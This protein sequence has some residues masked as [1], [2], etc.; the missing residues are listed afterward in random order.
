MEHTLD[1]TNKGLPAAI[2]D[3]HSP[4]TLCSILSYC[5]LRA[6]WSGAGVWQ[7]LLLL[8]WWLLLACWL[9]DCSLRKANIFCF[10]DCTVRSCSCS[11]SVSSTT[12]IKCSQS[13]FNQTGS[14]Y[15][16]IEFLLFNYIGYQWIVCESVITVGI[17]RPCHC[18][19]EFPVF[20]LL[21]NREYAI[22]YTG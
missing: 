9:S 8:L 19:T 7:L 5:C 12:R 11:I 4:L 14:N 13:Y 22:C 3:R 21:S 20:F 1:C 2:R 10:R 17:Q 15:K 18:A 6:F 16:I